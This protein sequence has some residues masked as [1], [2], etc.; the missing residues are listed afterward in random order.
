MLETCS[1]ETRVLALVLAQALEYPRQYSHELSSTRLITRSST[2]ASTRVFACTHM[3]TP[4]SHCPAKVLR[5]AARQAALAP[6]AAYSFGTHGWCSAGTS[7]VLRQHPTGVLDRG[8]VSTAAGRPLRSQFSYPSTAD[9]SDA[10]LQQ[11]GP[12]AQHCT[13]GTRVLTS[14]D[15][16]YQ[17]PGATGYSPVWT[18]SECLRPPHVAAAAAEVREL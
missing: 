5:T 9:L 2:R 6:R 16:L 8:T 10:E 14:M 7:P 13:E 1:L 18:D 4:P 3:G 17:M 12:S 15:G 11:V